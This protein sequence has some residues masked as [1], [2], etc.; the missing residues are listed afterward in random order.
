MTGWSV[1]AIIRLQT[2]RSA[3]CE[4]IIIKREEKNSLARQ[5]ILDAAM[6]EFSEKG[7]GGASLN[8]LCT[9]HDI[10]K[11]MIYHY[12]RDRDELYLYCVRECF[13]ALTTHMKEVPGRLTGPPEQRLKAYFDARLRFFAEHPLH[14]GMFADAVFHPPAALTAEIADCRRSFDAL[15]IAILTEFLES[16]PQTARF[17]IPAIVEDFRMYMDFFNMRFQ[18][19]VHGKVP[20]EAIL[21]EHEERCHRQLE[22]LLHGVLG[23]SHE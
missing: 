12:F 14:L 16:Q 8:T 2:S 22:V 1:C 3:F 6:R 17:P 11:G 18:E 7:Y 13:E 23:E 19:S 20:T 21:Q 10:S 4:V 15:N 5:R 9:E